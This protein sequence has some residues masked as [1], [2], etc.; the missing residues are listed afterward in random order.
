MLYWLLDISRNWLDGIGLYSYLQI[1]DRLTFRALAAAML[2]FAAVLVFGKPVIAWLQRKKIGDSGLTD[3]AGLAAAANSKK[4]VPTMGGILIVGAIIGA[5][6]LLADIR[7]FYVLL[8]LVVLVWL[9][10]LGGVDDWLKLTAARRPTASRQGLVAWEK[11]V[12]QIGLGLLVGY[13]AWQHGRAPGAPV[14]LAHVLNLP[15]QKTFE[16]SSGAIADGLWYLTLGGFTFVAVVM[17]TGM[18]NAVN[19]TDGMDGLAA[20]TMGIVSLGLLVLTFIAGWQQA[21]QYLLVPYVTES[22]ELAV[23]VGATAG[24]CVGF[25]WFNCLPARVFMGDTG[26]LALGG[27]LGYVA[28]IIRQEVI[29]IFMSA[30]FAIETASVAMQVGYFKATKG[31]RIFKCAPY[32]HHLHMSGWTEGQ[33]V[34]RFWIITVLLV[35]IGLASIKVR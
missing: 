23:M 33:V 26:A 20:G 2:A 27:L 11:L 32:H 21:A 28:L 1:L 29:V 5:T 24:A 6:L 10:V 17:I 31:K 8:G 25:L 15:L 4:N 18:S 35:V 13:F 30:I 3:A 12:F 14:N 16:S 34:T 7:N 19:I 9:A 22:Q